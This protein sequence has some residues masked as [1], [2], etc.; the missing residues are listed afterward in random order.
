MPHIL[1]RKSYYD[2]GWSSVD[3]PYGPGG[4]WSDEPAISEAERRTM[5]NTRESKLFEYDPRLDETTG[6]TGVP[7]VTAMRVQGEH[8]A[9]EPVPQGYAN[10]SFETGDDWNPESRIEHPPDD[11]PTWNPEVES[12]YE[13]DPI[14][15]ARYRMGNMGS[16]RFLDLPDAESGTWVTRP[17]MG[18][19]RNIYT[20]NHPEKLVFI[21]GPIDQYGKVHRRDSD[22]A[23]ENLAEAFI[24]HDK[25]IPP[26][27]LVTIPLKDKYKDSF[28]FGYALTAQDAGVPDLG[29]N[30]QVTSR[31]SDALPPFRKSEERPHALMSNKDLFE[32][33]NEIL[34]YQSTDDNLRDFYTRGND[35]Y[36]E[37]LQEAFTRRQ[38]NLPEPSF[39]ALS[40][41]PMPFDED[42]QD[43][44]KGE[45]I[46]LAWR[47]LKAHVL[48]KGQYSPKELYKL[49][50]DK[51]VGEDEL[52]PLDVTDH[53][54]NQAV[55]RGFL[56][57]KHHRGRNQQIV[58]GEGKVFKPEGGYSRF[59]NPTDYVKR[60]AQIFLHEHGI[61]DA[62]Q[63]PNGIKIHFGDRE[64]DSFKDKTKAHKGHRD[65]YIGGYTAVLAPNS[66]DPSKMSLVSLY[67]DSERAFTRD[68]NRMI[69]QT[70]S[71]FD[72]KPGFGSSFSSPPIGDNGEPFHD[73]TQRRRD[74]APPPTISQ[75]KQIIP[76][77]AKQFLNDH[78]DHEDHLHTNGKAMFSFTGK[79]AKWAAGKTLPG[80][81]N[82]DMNR[83]ANVIADAL[84]HVYTNSELGMS[85]DDVHNLGESMY[86]AWR[87][88]YEDKQ[89]MPYHFNSIQ[90]PENTPG[91]HVVNPDMMHSDM[92][93]AGDPMEL[94][95]RLLK[96]GNVGSVRGMGSGA[97]DNIYH[98]PHELDYDSMASYMSGNPNATLGDMVSPYLQGQFT[99]NPSTNPPAYQSQAQTQFQ[100]TVPAPFPQTSEQ[101]QGVQ[102]LIDEGF[103]DYQSRDS[104]RKPHY[105][106]M[107]NAVRVLSRN[108]RANPAFDFAPPGRL[109]GV[110][111]R[112]KSTGRT[113]EM[114]NMKL[115]SMLDT[116]VSLATATMTPEQGIPIAAGEPMNIAFQLLKERKS[117]EAM[118]HKREYDKKYES[119]PER[120]KYR[121]QLNRERRRRGIYGSG[122][123]MDV[124][125]TQGGRLTLEGEHANR[126]RH[127]KN[128]GTLR[129]VRVR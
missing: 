74:M 34:H 125:H 123:H 102:Q 83:T 20:H 111:G 87:Q 107:N 78:F 23:R 51:V 69:G 114:Q 121:E 127:F 101:T 93:M 27:R 63:V 91:A 19:V 77:A 79:G 7:P 116:P 128:R 108:L 68:E 52:I 99:N 1:V 94:A 105:D 18:D 117:P 56:K 3:N 88:H 100:N 44:H 82:N 43:A 42:F 120:V 59:R 115:R 2:E 122:D 22:Q 57:P 39:G 118:R 97:T 35:E 31:W 112:N 92:V 129:R 86:G 4:A 6:W 28:G 17:T 26:E 81:W 38:E 113:R 72:D 54:Y 60:L 11:D 40:E 15:G 32:R 29:T 65:S 71:L 124:S 66:E 75:T 48:P 45:P 96:A 70:Y 126:A 9:G 30:R 16:R 73:Y 46:D 98:Y 53:F 14:S 10:I 36:D 106:S 62:S 55:S 13:R 84:N 76:A 89:A 58:A 110:R 25:N 104:A 8:P 103:D 12:E 50:Q 80:G 5:A 90:L 95:F 64:G 67:G 47:L 49:I 109:R 37:L 41:P 33:I 85:L 61:N 24:E 119:S 21:R